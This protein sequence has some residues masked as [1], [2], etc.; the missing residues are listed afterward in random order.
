[1]DEIRDYTLEAKHIY[2]MPTAGLDVP[3]KVGSPNF[4]FNHPN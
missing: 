2:K 3:F 1:M 4:Y